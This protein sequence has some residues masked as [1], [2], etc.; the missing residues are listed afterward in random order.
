MDVAWSTPQGALL[1]RIAHYC[2]LIYEAKRARAVEVVILVRTHAFTRI[3]VYATYLKRYFPLLARIDELLSEL[4]DV[5]AGER[6]DTLCKR[7]LHNKLIKTVREFIKS[8][9]TALKKGK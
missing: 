8:H 9:L 3:L 6:L 1:T 2:I 7:G 4:E 5:S